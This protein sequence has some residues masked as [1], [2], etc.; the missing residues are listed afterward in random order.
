MIA[1]WCDGAASKN[2]QKD[3]IGG[4][5][6]V[7]KVNN[8][9]YCSGGQSIGVTNQ[10]ME[11]MAA[12]DALKWCDENSDDKFIIVVTDSA[13][14]YRCWVEGWW[15]NWETNGWKNSSKQPVANKEL[16]EQLIPYFRHSM[17][18]FEKVKG[19]Q[20]NMGNQYAD[21]LAVAARKLDR[22]NFVEYTKTILEELND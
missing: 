1:V 22:D 19:H 16:W 17:V 8:E 13:Y 18:M 7:A 12:I 20:D 14:L 5:G 15:K 9:F 6:W 11:L 3:A 21:K 10:Q 2:G 4:Y